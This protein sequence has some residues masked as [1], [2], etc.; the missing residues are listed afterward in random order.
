MQIPVSTLD[1]GE[2]GALGCAAL[3]AVATGVYA[4]VEEAA[5]NMSRVKEVLEPNKGNREFYREKFEQY[6]LLHT[7]LREESEYACR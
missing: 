7:H 1:C 5:Q 2:A 4:S 3:C 6:R